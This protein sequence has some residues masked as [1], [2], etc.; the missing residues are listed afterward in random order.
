MSERTTIRVSP[1]TRDALWA[2]LAPRTL[3]FWKLQEKPPD[4]LTEPEVEEAEALLDYFTGLRREVLEAK[5]SLSNG[6]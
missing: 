4:A 3:R 6:R 1:G 2:Q 5:V